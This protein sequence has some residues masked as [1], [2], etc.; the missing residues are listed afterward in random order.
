[1]RWEP[2]FDD[3][4]GEFAHGLAREEAALAAEEERLRFARLELAE[5]L[6]G[7]LGAE[8][9]LQLRDGGALRLRLESVGRDWIA[10]RAAH[11]A[12]ESAL[13]PVPA[14]VGLVAEASA[15]E[16]AAAPAASGLERRLGIAVALR[17]L[18]RRRAPVELLTDRSRLRGTIDRVAR[19]HL[20]L[21]EHELDEPRRDAAVRRT[22][23]VALATL[24]CVRY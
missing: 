1:M 17:D 8:V 18:T 2:V 20:D 10:G 16:P 22:R 19:D 14:V 7:L 11:G 23:L 6:T 9:E 15:L 4:E 3:L 24:V 21:A 12:L 13:V 5:R